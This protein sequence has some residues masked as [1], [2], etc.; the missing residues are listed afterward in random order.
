M[1]SAYTAQ[2]TV[3]ADISSVTIPMLPGVSWMLAPSGSQRSPLAMTSAR[4]LV[5]TATSASSTMAAAPDARAEPTSSTRGRGGG[6]GGRPGEDLDVGGGGGHQAD[7]SVLSAAR[8]DA[9][10]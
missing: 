3:T 7:A 8:T 1:R 6:G 5:Y 4:M 2:A 10:A 9:P